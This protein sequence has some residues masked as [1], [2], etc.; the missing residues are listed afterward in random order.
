[1]E[2]APESF[3]W[4]SCQSLAGQCVSELNCIWRFFP[5]EQRFCLELLL[6]WQAGSYNAQPDHKIVLHAPTEAEMYYSWRIGVHHEE[7]WIHSSQET[8]RASDK[9]EAS[10]RDGCW[11]MS[12][13]TGKS[14]FWAIPSTCLHTL[15]L[16]V[17]A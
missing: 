6:G 7:N 1:M 17:L 3:K 9:E 15:H 4:C 16:C 11:I 2:P 14:T 13:F 10:T 8:I 5:L 12:Y